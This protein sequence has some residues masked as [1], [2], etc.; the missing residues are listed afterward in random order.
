MLGFFIKAAIQL[1]AKERSPGYSCQQKY[2][3]SHHLP[4]A[5]SGN[6]TKISGAGGNKRGQFDLMVRLS[7]SALP[8]GEPPSDNVPSRLQVSVAFTRESIWIQASQRHF[9]YPACG[10]PLASL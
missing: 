4:A 10:S 9:V 6:S 8:L 5:Y 1:H 7:L 3:N 2:G